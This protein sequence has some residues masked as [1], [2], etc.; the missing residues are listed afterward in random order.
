MGLGEDPRVVAAIVNS[1]ASARLLTLGRDPVSRGPTVEAAHEAL[2]SGWPRLAGWIEAATEDVRVFA[3]LTGATQE[4][5]DADRSDD[6]LLTGERL[7]ATAAWAASTDLGVS[8]LERDFIDASTARREEAKRTERE[9]QEHAATL[10]RRSVRRLRGIVAITLAAALVGGVLGAFAFAQQSQAEREARGARARDFVS[11][12]YLALPRDPELAALLALEAVDVDP[13]VRRNAAALLHLALPAHRTVLALPGQAAATAPDDSWIVTG[14]ATGKVRTFDAGTGEHIGEVGRHDTE[15]T[16]LAV[17]ADGALVASGDGDGSVRIWETATGSQAGGWDDASAGTVHT[18]RFTPDAKTLAVAVENDSPTLRDRSGTVVA[19][20]E[21]P[22]RPEVAERGVDLTEDGTTI[23]TPAAVFDVPTGEVITAPEH[24]GEWLTH[25]TITPDGQV[26]AG[27]SGFFLLTWRADGEEADWTRVERTITAVDIRDGGEQVAAGAKDGAVFIWEVGGRR[28]ETLSGH[29]SEVTTV[30]FLD[31][32]ERLLTASSDGTTRI[33]DLREGADRELL[34]HRVHE[35]CAMRVGLSGD[36][37]RVATVDW[38]SGGT[39]RVLDT[40]NGAAVFDNNWYS[41]A[42]TVALDADGSTLVGAARTQQA[43]RL[44]AGEPIP[45][46]DAFRTG[47]LVALSPDGTSAAFVGRIAETAIVTHRAVG[48]DEPPF[49]I[50]GEGDISAVAYAPEGPRIVIGDETGLVIADPTEPDARARLK[51]PDGLIANDVAFSVDGERV[52]ASWREGGVS[53]FAVD[54]GEMLMN[55]DAAPGALAVGFN[56]DGS[57]LAVFHSDQRLQ[58]LDA[59][60]GN[61]MVTIIDHNDE[62]TDMAVSADGRRLATVAYDGQVRVYAFDE[63]ELF[64]LARSRMTR[65]FTAEECR[66]YGLP[67]P[68]PVA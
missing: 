36:G 5:L 26:A 33:W 68:C 21:A 10:E 11:A 48:V 46:D 61:L 39:V 67:D 19:S 59:A 2:L 23:V 24:F 27:A 15:V 44:P 65:G 63:G 30:Q 20:F 57:T 43:W 8:A 55:H 51:H 17:S 29:D 42:G 9:R 50:T 7:E 62:G 58:L 12:A 35:C 6:Y 25:G 56:S 38:E 34:T 3:R 66:R 37:S 54:S 31:D 41:K 60:T 16:A 14:D 49:D 4:W 28:G 22:I 13:A 18:L 64:D 47:G 1:F 40:S 52:A 32:G 45:L 53:V